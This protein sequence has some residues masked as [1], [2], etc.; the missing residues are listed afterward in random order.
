MSWQVLQGTFSEP[1]NTVKKSTASCIFINKPMFSLSASSWSTQGVLNTFMIAAV[2]AIDTVLNSN[3]LIKV[4]SC[5]P[6]FYFKTVNFRP[7]FIM[8]GNRR[9]CRK[10]ALK[11][12]KRHGFVK[13]TELIGHCR[14]L[15]IREASF[16][17][18]S[19]QN[20][21]RPRSE[22]EDIKDVIPDFEKKRRQMCNIRYKV[23]GSLEL[24][25]DSIAEK[26][27]EIVEE[28]QNND[29][30]IVNLFI[31]YSPDNDFDGLVD[32]LVRTGRTK[33]LSGF[34]LKQVS[35]G[36][37]ITF[38]DCFWPEITYFHIVLIYWKFLLER[39]LLMWK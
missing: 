25:E 21:G 28:T 1:Q 6:T 39:R 3:V 31:A 18:L 13:F 22:I 15:G 11:N 19:K 20:L 27:R 34:L 30:I 4:F 12:A 5:I 24:L 36:A 9:F 29:G 33:R 38:L 10:K 17:V 23:I 35:Q 26:L 14:G 32:V 7:A 37:H 8:D 2:D 16:F